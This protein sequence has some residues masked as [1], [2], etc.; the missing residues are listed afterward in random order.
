MNILIIENNE[1]E[2][3]ELK[4][5]FLN[6][7]KECNACKVEAVGF[8]YHGLTLVETSKPTVIILNETLPDVDG[9]SIVKCIRKS[10]DK[11]GNPYIILISSNPDESIESESYLSGANDIIP[12][13]F[14][15]LILMNKM[16]NLGKCLL[17][18]KIDILSDSKIYLFNEL[19]INDSIKQVYYSGNEVR[20][21]KKEYDLL[22]YLIK[23][24]NKAMKREEIME[25]VWGTNYI[26]IT[27][28]AVDSCI[29]KLK[30]KIPMLSEYIERIFKFGYCLKS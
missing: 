23:N 30:S 16:K 14:S 25:N 29:C 8:G 7:C 9:I 21:E 13:P 27:D 6:A 18:K 1:K 11:Y 26:G 4:N 5:L 19:E 3:I 17:I 22:I 10:P 24:K 2:R 12:H 28:R 20:L 15:P